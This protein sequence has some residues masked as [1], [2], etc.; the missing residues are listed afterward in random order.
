MRF[1][2]ILKYFKNDSIET[3]ELNCITDSLPSNEKVAKEILNS[4][5]NN[6]TKVVFDEDIK[7]SYYVYFQDTI[8]IADTEKNK[9]YRRICLIAHECIHS[10]Q[11]KLLQNINFIL[12]NIELIAFI[13]CLV[14]LIVSK[15]SIPLYVYL[16]ICAIS[17]VPRCILEIDAVKRSVIVSKG[18]L[19]EKLD[20]K[21]VDK[22]FNVYSEQINLLLPMAFIS[23]FFEKIIRI[24]IM[25]L[26]TIII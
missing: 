8:Y 13:A 24:L 12:S 2:E 14:I 9:T 11:S 20:S 22:L 6:N 15:N 17:I 26:V 4:L 7:N 10:V 3:K 16:T 5:N 25:V 1:F 23:L 21:S 19:K 18:Y